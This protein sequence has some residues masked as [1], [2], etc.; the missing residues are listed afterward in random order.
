MRKYKK[1]AHI[2]RLRAIQAEC[3]RLRDKVCQRCG[4]GGG[5]LDT[6]HVFPKGKHPSMQFLMENVK[7][8]CSLKC[9]K[10]WW[11]THPIE[12]T[13][14]FKEKFPE[15][16]KFLLKKSQE[17]ILVDRVFLD[18]V[19]IYLKELRAEYLSNA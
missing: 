18:Q 12:A 15:R 17:S 19:E 4:S 13:K 8:L 9:H 7:L 14:W 16:Y 1:T 6:S 3:C 11:H 10:Y 2:K 5:K